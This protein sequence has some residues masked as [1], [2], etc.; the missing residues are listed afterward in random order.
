MPRTPTL[1]LTAP[2][3][4][5]EEEQIALLQRLRYAEARCPE[6][7]LLFAIPNGGWRF[8]KTAARLKAA[9]V[10]AGVPDLF[11]PVA[12]RNFHGLFIEMK[13]LKGGVVSDAQ[14]D[15]ITDLEAQGYAVYVCRGWWDA[16]KK[17]CWYLGIQEDE[18]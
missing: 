14:L 17:L 15:W 7:A 9:G 5:E 18:R 6:L 16:W 8:P 10:K 13:R 2:T 11:L 3:M 1:T 12:R 4:S